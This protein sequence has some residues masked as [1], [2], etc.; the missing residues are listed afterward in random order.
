MALPINIEDLLNKRKVESNRIEF[1]SGWNPDKI[2]HTICAFLQEIITQLKN[3]DLQVYIADVEDVRALINKLA[4]L[5]SQVYLQVWK[6]AQAKQSVLISNVIR[7]FLMLRKAKLTSNELIKLL[8]VESLYKLRRYILNPVI[9]LGLVEM[10]NPEK[11]TSSKQRYG[12]TQSG[13]SL[14]M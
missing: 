3:E 7:L 14:F 10:S 6:T 5:I 9:S 12:L 1:K 8:H 4:N 13:L 11:P 2:Y